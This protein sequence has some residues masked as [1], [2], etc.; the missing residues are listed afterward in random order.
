MSRNQK[1]FCKVCQDAG[2]PESEYTGH[3][4]KDRSGNV[5]CPTLLKT[6]CRFCFKKGHTSKYC[7][8]TKAPPAIR[9]N[10]ATKS[11]PKSAAAPPKIQNCFSVL[12]ASD[13]EEEQIQEPVKYVPSGWAAV[14]AKQPEIEI[15]KEEPINDDSDKIV[16]KPRSQ[17]TESYNKPAPWVTEPQQVKRSWVEMSDSEDEEE[18]EQEEVYNDAW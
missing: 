17:R 10:P 4:V 9:P 7:T 6:E 18:E 11:T 15:K 16:L 14:A 8:K 5:T 1:P 2:K 13:D 3:W 12:D